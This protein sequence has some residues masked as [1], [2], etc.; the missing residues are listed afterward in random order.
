MHYGKGGTIRGKG[1]CRV[2]SPLSSAK[3]PKTF[4]K[5][6]R[7]KGVKMRKIIFLGFLKVRIKFL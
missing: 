3:D 4:I 2:L 1:S 5:S 7:M 6:A